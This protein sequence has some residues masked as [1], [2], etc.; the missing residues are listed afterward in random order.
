MTED[1]S[2]EGQ[3]QVEIHLAAAEFPAAPGSTTTIPVLV[4]N[5]GQK[6]D[7]LTLTVDG[8]EGRL[9]QHVD[10]LEPTRAGLL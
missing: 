7:V 8:L 9:P 2:F 1:S 3:P 10:E 5:R 6:E 4:Q